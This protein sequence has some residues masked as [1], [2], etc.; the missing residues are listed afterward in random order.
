MLRNP[1]RLLGVH[2][3]LCAAAAKSAWDCDFDLYVSE[4]YRS[5]DRQNALYAQGRTNPGAVVTN[6]QA[7]QSAHNFGLAVDIYPA[8]EDGSFNPQATSAVFNS[9]V[10]TLSDSMKSIGGVTWGGD[11]TSLQD[12]PHYEITDWQNNE[13]WQVTTALILI[14]VGMAVAFNVF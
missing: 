6:A 1:Q 10:Q 14:T 12:R 3:R 11:F 13:N 9:R 8:D 2:P 7:G 4:G 5:D